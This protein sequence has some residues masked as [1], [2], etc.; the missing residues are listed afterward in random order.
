MQ[1]HWLDPP[2][3]SEERD[4]QPQQAAMEVGAMTG[5]SHGPVAGWT[6]EHE[7]LKQDLDA[8]YRERGNNP[9]IE[10]WRSAIIE[11]VMRELNGSANVPAASSDA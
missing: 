4:P 6:V 7:M 2:G 5:H 3:G 11:A 1:Q 9:D 10:P 8:L